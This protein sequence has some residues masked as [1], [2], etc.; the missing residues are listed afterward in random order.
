MGMASI[1]NLSGALAMKVLTYLLA[2]AILFVLCASPADAA[3]K[4]NKKNEGV[5]GDYAGTVVSI[6][7]GEGAESPA[8][9]T[10]KTAGKKKKSP[11][12]DRRFELSKS[13]RLESVVIAKKAFG[14]K[15]A[16]I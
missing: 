6:A 15:A 9:L 3:K 12:T 13:V 8:V 4:K 16:T 10:I 7:K 2:P 5:N 14:L 11:G 1:R